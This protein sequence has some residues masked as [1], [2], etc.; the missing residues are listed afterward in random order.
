M[1]GCAIEISTLIMIR[2][3]YNSN[4]AISKI[5]NDDP[6]PSENWYDDV[7]HEEYVAASDSLSSGKI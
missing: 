5:S 7:D 2:H 1:H 6:L 3:Y 4:I